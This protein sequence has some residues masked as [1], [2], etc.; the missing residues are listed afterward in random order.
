MHTKSV[1]K[2]HG[3]ETWKVVTATAWQEAVP[4]DGL[5]VTIS[6]QVFVTLGARPNSA[7]KLLPVHVAS[8]KFGFWTCFR[9]H[10]LRG[11]LGTIKAQHHRIV[12]LTFAKLTN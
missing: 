6:S 5:R 7:F 8:G 2:A 9:A 3:G 12:P 1:E 10:F 4:K 11:Y